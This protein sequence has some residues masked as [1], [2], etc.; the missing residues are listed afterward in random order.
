MSDSPAGSCLKIR[1]I[2][3]TMMSA[4]SITI[5]EP[6]FVQQ[7]NL[8]AIFLMESTHELVTKPLGHG[9]IPPP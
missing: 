4:W 6:A 9:E 1:F 7:P 2:S 8:S 5:E 3:H